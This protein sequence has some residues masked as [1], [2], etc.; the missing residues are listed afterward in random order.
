MTRKSAL[1]VAGLLAS[2]VLPGCAS[3][4]AWRSGSP[5][6][7]TGARQSQ[8]IAAKNILFNPMCNSAPAYFREA[9]S[10][11]S[12]PVFADQREEIW[13]RE[14]VYDRQGL[15]GSAPDLYYRRFYSTRIGQARR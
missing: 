12:T 15:S 2:I 1:L 3:S 14:T 10:W 11:P 9:S 13:Y 7:T 5:R 8:E 6:A 4:A